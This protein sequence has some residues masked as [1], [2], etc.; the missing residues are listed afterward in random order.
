MLQH[1]YYDFYDEYNQKYKKLVVF[2]QVG[3][4]YEMYSPLDYSRTNLVQLKSILKFSIITKGIG[5]NQFLMIGFP[6][7]GLT[8]YKKI[9]DDNMYTV[10]VIDEMNDFDKSTENVLKMCG[11]KRRKIVSI[12]SPG[13]NF[14][15]VTFFQK[16]LY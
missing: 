8:K 12:L 5:N 9:M 11:G 7:S 14:D 3:G 1:D 15:S 4:F 2:M 10:I 13:T 16:V 6:T